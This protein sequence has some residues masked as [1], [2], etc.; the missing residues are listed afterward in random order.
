MHRWGTKPPGIVINRKKRFYD[1]F[2]FFVEWIY[3]PA[4]KQAKNGTAFDIRKPS[5]T[6][7]L[8]S[9]ATAGEAGKV[10]VP[11]PGSRAAERSTAH[12]KPKKAPLMLKSISSFKNRFKR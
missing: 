8:A 10:A 3:F 9:L 12:T 6:A 4:R 1:G 7:K 5:T 11:N 2:S